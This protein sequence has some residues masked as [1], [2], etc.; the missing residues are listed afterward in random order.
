MEIERNPLMK[1]EITVLNFELTMAQ[2][3]KSIIELERSFNNKNDKSNEA[4]LKQQ[5]LAELTH[6][7]QKML[8]QNGIN[9]IELIQYQVQRAS[10]EI[11]VQQPK[12]VNPNQLS[13]QLS[14]LK[15]QLAEHTA[16]V[17]LSTIDSSKGLEFLSVVLCGVWR[18]RMDSDD[19]RRL[20]YVGMTRAMDNLKIITKKENPFIDDLLKAVR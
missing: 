13:V 18:G 9:H 8:L 2:L 12:N 19:N 15:E 20:L 6:K 4:T 1:K 17:I 3:G 10:L 5:Q 7:H 16:P 11:G 14:A